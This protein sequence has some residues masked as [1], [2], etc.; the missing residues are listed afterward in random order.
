MFSYD[1][2]QL[3]YGE[4][5]YKRPCR[6][7]IGESRDMGKP[8]YSEG[9]GEGKHFDVTHFNEDSDSD[10][11]SSLPEVTFT[12]TRLFWWAWNWN[13]VYAEELEM[14]EERDRSHEEALLHDREEKEHLQYL[15]ASCETFR[16]PSPEVK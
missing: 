16:S 6:L 11:D 12:H 4:P 3:S 14:A 13:E 2:A 15:I 1:E 10:S 7:C 9:F 8:I 5:K